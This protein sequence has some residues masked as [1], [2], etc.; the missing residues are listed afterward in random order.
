[1]SLEEN[2]FYEFGPFRIDSVERRLMRGEEPVP[3]TPKAYE[4]LLL[5]VENAGRGLE[6]DELLR[7]VW[8]DTFVEEGS[9]TRAIYV[10]RKALGDGDGIYIETLPKRGY[11]F[12][13]PVR[14]FPLAAAS[15]VVE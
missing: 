12:V 9:L 14:Q 11:R 7:H 1:M 5:L 2:H 15:L 6:K 8:P 13:A 4:T 3:L 10:L